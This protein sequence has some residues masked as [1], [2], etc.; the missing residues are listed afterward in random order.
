MSTAT[1]PALPD[2]LRRDDFKAPE[3]KTARARVMYA[4]MR[5]AGGSATPRLYSYSQARRFV[6][7]A[8]RFGLDLYHVKFGT[9]QA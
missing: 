8:K 1:I 3:V 9:V 5:G 2:S 7:L 4:I 6:R